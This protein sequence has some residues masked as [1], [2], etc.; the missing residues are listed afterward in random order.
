MIKTNHH[1]I[2]GGELT[3]AQKTAIVRQL[4]AA[5]TDERDIQKFY[6]KMKADGSTYPGYFLPL[7][8]NNKMYQTVIPMSPKTHI[9]SMNAYEMDILRLLHLFA[10]ENPTVKDMVNGTFKRLKNSCPGGDCTQ[11]EC[12]HSSLPVLRFLA[13]AKRDD[14]EWMNKLTAKIHRGIEWKYKT[15]A[16]LYYW[17]CLSELPYDVA[18]PG[19]LKY[20]KEI[21]KKL[22]KTVPLNTEYNKIYQPV[23]YCVYRNCLVAFP[24]YEHIKTRQP[25]E[26][27]GRL[28]FDINYTEME[29]GDGSCVPK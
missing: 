27:K 28:C 1:I 25:Y 7:Y 15:N 3:D 22:E 23:L 4:L 26:K 19:L 14:K 17:L 9:L 16:I 10:P 11:G 21:I 6:S 2:K 18:E 20:K 24:E 8:N 29:R 13:V 5:R 12:F